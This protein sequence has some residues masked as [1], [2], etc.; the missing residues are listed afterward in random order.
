[1]RI[2][3]A[4][5]T[6]IQSA[7]T[8]FMNNHGMALGAGLSY[9]FVLS[10]FPLLIALSCIVPY[11]PVPNLWDKLLFTMSRIM[12][13]EAM[14]LVQKVVTDVLAQTHPKLL[15]VGILGTIYAATGGFSSMIEA[16]N[17]AYDVPE[18]R[19]W[20][21][22]R[23]LALQ[24]TLVIGIFFVVALAVMV[25][26]PQ[27]GG[28]LATKIGLGSIFAHIWNYLR[29]GVSVAFT[30]IGIELLYFMAPNVKQRFWATLPGAVLA[31]T[32]WIAASYGLGIYFQ[33]FANFNKTYGT[34]GAVVALFMWLYWT[35]NF[36]LFGA[37]LNSELRK[38]AGKKPLPVKENVI[39]IDF[40]KKTA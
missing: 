25:V 32:A 26:G 7:A 39:P 2:V 9:Y 14:G 40:G 21:R 20:W 11:L 3:R 30:V 37:E 13:S 17:V 12:P 28:W 29:W 15:S 24:L 35:N 8:D 10:L 23:L 6:A 34:L 38:A 22:T 31:V 1:V 4:C 19:P 27:F 33:K 18:T 36:I 5:K 16:L